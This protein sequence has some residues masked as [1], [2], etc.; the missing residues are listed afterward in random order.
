MPEIARS[1]KTNCLVK[2]NKIGIKKIDF[3]PL[4]KHL[5]SF[6]QY[7]ASNLNSHCFFQYTIRM[8]A[9]KIP[10]KEVLERKMYSPEFA[11]NFQFDFDLLDRNSSYL[12]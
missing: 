11:L 4:L 10:C 9:A 2:K 3:L 5:R 8:I 7:P 1:K 6:V 12:Q